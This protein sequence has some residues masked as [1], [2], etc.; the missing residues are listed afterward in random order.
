MPGNC[1]R[2]RD[3]TVAVGRG[4][5]SVGWDDK[6]TATLV[7]SNGSYQHDLIASAYRYAHLVAG[8][9]ITGLSG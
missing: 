4:T 8:L 5:V 2:N 1:V 6:F 3:R 9:N 7:F